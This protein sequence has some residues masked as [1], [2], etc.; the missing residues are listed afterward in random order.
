[1]DNMYSE[2]VYFLISG[3]IENGGIRNL[4]FFL[5]NEELG[6]LFKDGDDLAERTSTKSST[7]KTNG[8]SSERWLSF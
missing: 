6:R 2:T 5:M 4:H 7:Q 8:T 3:K 1:M